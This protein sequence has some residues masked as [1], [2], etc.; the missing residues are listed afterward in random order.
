[1]RPLHCFL[2]RVLYNGCLNYQDQSICGE[3]VKVSLVRETATFEEAKEGCVQR[4]SSLARISTQLE[5]FKAGNAAIK[6]A[7]SNQQRL[8]W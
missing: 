3:G 4:N 8:D 2:V 7:S 1:M 6:E 5:F